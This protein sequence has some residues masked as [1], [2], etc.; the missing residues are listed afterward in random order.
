M[1]KDPEEERKERE[2]KMLKEIFEK[3]KNF[4]KLSSETPYWK[5]KRKERKRLIEKFY[6]EVLRVEYFTW[7][8]PAPEKKKS[9]ENWKKILEIWGKG[10][11]EEHFRSESIIVEKREKIGY[12]IRRLAKEICTSIEQF[13]MGIYKDYIYENILPAAGYLRNDVKSLAKMDLTPS[14]YE[15]LFSLKGF[16]LEEFLSTNPEI[17]ERKSFLYTYYSDASCR[18]MGSDVYCLRTLG[19]GTGSYSTISCNTGYYRSPTKNKKEDYI[20]ALELVN[21]IQKRVME[22]IKDYT[23]VS[24]KIIEIKLPPKPKITI[25]KCANCGWETAEN[26]KV[27]EKCGEAL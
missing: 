7:N 16:I 8:M 24:K 2:K 11:F 19:L 3:F 23:P 18:S 27:C 10:F 25:L 1:I 5:I 4:L 21:R 9:Y 22:L 12:S 17:R 13:Q 26:V 14:E 6:K 15:N 20:I